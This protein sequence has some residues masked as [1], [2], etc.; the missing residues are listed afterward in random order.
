LQSTTLKTTE[1]FSKLPV[2]AN[3]LGNLWRLNALCKLQEAKKKSKN[4]ITKQELLAIK[5]SLMQ[6][7]TYFKKVDC[8]WGLG[9]TY[10]MLGRIH[11]YRNIY[12]IQKTRIYFSEAMKCFILIT[13]YRGTYMTLKSIHDLELKVISDQ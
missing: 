6:A 1:D 4:T 3:F 8:K 10:N 5:E 11:T 13:H 7:L 9:L 12:D 2:S